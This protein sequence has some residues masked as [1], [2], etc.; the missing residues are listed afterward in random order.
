MNITDIIQSY[1][2][3]NKLNDSFSIKLSRKIL[4]KAENELDTKLQKE[5]REMFNLIQNRAFEVGYKTSIEL[6]IISS[7]K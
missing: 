5:L 4:K 2:I 7:L 1:K 6:N 3:Q